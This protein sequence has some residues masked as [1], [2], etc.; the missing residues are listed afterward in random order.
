MEESWGSLLRQGT[1]KPI[2]SFTLRMKSQRMKYSKLTR[3]RIYQS[4]QIWFL[5]VWIDQSNT[6]HW[7]KEAAWDSLLTRLL[8]T[9]ETRNWG[10]RPILWKMTE[11]LREELQIREEQK[12]WLDSQILVTQ[13]SRT[14]RFLDL[15]HFRLRT[16]WSE[17]H[18][19]Q[20]GQNTSREALSSF[21]QGKTGHYNPET[22]M[23]TLA[24]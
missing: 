24:Q 1:I 3:A 7:T 15:L 9:L 11:N 20:N 14:S 8:G 4:R 21:H 19:D 16:I 22:R 17:R 12:K 2:L 10:Q 13:N 6:S 23:Q 18:L 5:K